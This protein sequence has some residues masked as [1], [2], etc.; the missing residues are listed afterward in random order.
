MCL[1]C[2]LLV[3]RVGVDRFVDE[4]ELLNC[5]NGEHEWINI[6]QAHSPVEVKGI[7]VSEAALE[8]PRWTNRLVQ[9]PSAKPFK[10]PTSTKFP[11]EELY[12]S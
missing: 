3:R 8:L 5:R 9:H 12:G 2:G 11:K 4:A 7:E 6:D 10:Q 1:A